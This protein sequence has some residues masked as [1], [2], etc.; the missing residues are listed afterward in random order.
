MEYDCIIEYRTGIN[1]SHVDALSRNS[2]KD[3][4]NTQAY[5]DLRI[6]HIENSD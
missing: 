6:M 1:M 4:I 5:E 2:F 3:L